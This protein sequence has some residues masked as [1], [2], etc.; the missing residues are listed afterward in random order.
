MKPLVLASASPRRKALL[1][2]IGVAVQVMASNV[3][4]D[5]DGDPA[6]AAVMN[7]RAKR[8]DIAARLARPAVVV[9]AD[10]VVVSDGAVMGKPAD[11]AEAK[12]MLRRHS[13][14]THTVITGLAVSDTESGRVAE[15]F[16]TTRV[17]FRILTDEEIDRFV[18][19]VKPLDRA[20]AY[21]SD[22]PGA[23]LIERYDGCYQNVLGLPIV[24]LDRILREIGD[25]L[26]P[27]M[28]PRR[29]VFL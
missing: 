26:F 19:A 21:T 7:A 12:A 23:L 11:F 25:G 9:A 28:D 4:E 3:P 8:D 10:T 27:R 20:G 1:E 15:G 18:E 16:E 5:L 13:G 2:A 6:L 29:A 14:R 24:R 22:G 17:T